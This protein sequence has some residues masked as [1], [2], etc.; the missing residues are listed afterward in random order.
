MW[1]IGIYKG[2]EFT[3]MEPYKNNLNPVV[4]KKLITDVNAEFV[5]DPFMIQHDGMWYLF[6]EVLNTDTKKGEIGAAVSKDLI[7]WEYIGI[8][9]NEEFHLSYPFVFNY[10]NEI[11]MVPET[12]KAGG[13]VLYKATSFPTKW[14]P[15]KMLVQGQHADPTIVFHN[16][17]WWL[18]T[19]ETPY[20]YDSLSVFWATDLLGN[21][22]P[23]KLN[24]VYSNN[25]ANSRPA[26]RIIQS[27]GKLYRLFQN[28][29][30]IYGK[31]VG[32]AEILK[33]TPE[34]FK[35][36]ILPDPVLFPGGDFWNKERMHHMDCHQ[37]ADGT[38]VAC[39]D[40]YAK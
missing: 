34:E 13:V 2:S 14:E 31:S 16:D 5:A 35:D 9:L 40:G 3:K 38:L 1:S 27:K 18:F 6:F 36:R 12:L 11:Y 39:V 28:C 19:C 29:A 20:Q 30:E 33:L 32:G 22:Q 37:C 17:L 23:H 7:S 25:K 8:V 24:P 4:S 21:W 26:G 15:V 10:N